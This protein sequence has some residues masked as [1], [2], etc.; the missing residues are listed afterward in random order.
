MH[1]SYD[2]VLLEVPVKSN[3]KKGVLMNVVKVKDI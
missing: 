2:T 3:E 1:S